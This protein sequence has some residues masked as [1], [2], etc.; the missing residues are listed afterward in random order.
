MLEKVSDPQVLIILDIGIVYIVPEFLVYGRGFHY[1]PPIS[2]ADG[3]GE[4]RCSSLPL[5][6]YLFDVG[7]IEY[8]STCLYAYGLL[9][10]LYT[11]T[12][13]V[14]QVVEISIGV[15]PCYLAHGKSQAPHKFVDMVEA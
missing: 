6:G 2:V 15:F 3:L 8:G 9:H 7:R 13:M 11:S 14:A 12:M 4:S 10:L 1:V 5:L